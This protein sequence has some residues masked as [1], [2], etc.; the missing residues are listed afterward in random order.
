MS[1]F[2]IQMA[3]TQF[4]AFAAFSEPES[5]STGF[6]EETALYEKAIA[7]ANRLKPGFVVMCG[8][9][10]SDPDDQGQ[11]NELMRIT[12]RLDTRIPMHW[13]AGN[14]DVGGAPSDES[15]DKYRE[16]FG[17]DNYSFDHDG[18]H[19]IVLDSCVSYDPSNV[20]QEWDRQ[21]DFLKAD[22]QKARDSGCAQI[23]VFMHHPLF[24]RDP[25]EGD[26]TM[27]I[28]GERRRVL[29][30]LFK[31]HG[32]SAVFAGHWHRN[33]YASDGGLQ[34]VTSGPVGYPLGDDPSGL[35]IVKVYDDR[36]EHEYFGLDAL[37]EA[38]GLDD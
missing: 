33:N 32:V 5:N 25:G 26:S 30:D 7:A 18:S 13:V 21:V 28:P 27:A 9:M 1:F 16:R 17:R 22:L 36:L 14:C 24:G 4:G 37:P 11:I 15:L 8:D 19:F 29:L 6:A 38:V 23:V 35:R 2:F 3:D 12:G 31:R 34:M 20:P 10:V